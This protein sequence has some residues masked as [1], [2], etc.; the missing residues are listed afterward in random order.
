MKHPSE[1]EGIFPL[2]R[3][4]ARDRGLEKADPTK[5]MLKLMEETGELAEGMA[6]SREAQVVDSIGDI[7]VVLTVLCLQ[8]GLTPEYCLD[9]AYQE[10]KDRKGKMLNGVYVKAEDL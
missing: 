6:K 4:W 1:I 7:I 3:Q 2:I 10:I 9:L 5:Q 8:L